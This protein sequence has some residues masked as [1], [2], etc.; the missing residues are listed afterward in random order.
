ML[1]FLNVFGQSTQTWT[2]H[3]CASRTLQV[4]VSWESPIVPSVGDRLAGIYSV[5]SV[6]NVN[7]HTNE[8]YVALD[9]IPLPPCRM[10]NNAPN[11]HNMKQVN[12]LYQIA[13]QCGL[14][15]PWGKDQQQAIVWWSN[16]QAQL[17]NINN[18]FG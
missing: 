11:I 13:C 8:A 12:D 16:L 2:L 10:C 1:N 3:L 14:S 9:L 6:F 15:S 7:Y 4:F 5:V 18:L 17:L